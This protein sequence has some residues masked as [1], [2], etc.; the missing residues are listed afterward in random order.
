M[1]VSCFFMRTIT[2]FIRPKMK[3]KKTQ[4][5]RE[6]ELTAADYVDSLLKLHELQWVLL[7]DMKK[8]VQPKKK[9]RGKLPKKSN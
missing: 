9:V 2:G 1:V 6:K 8:A 3:S 5:K 7:N 4:V